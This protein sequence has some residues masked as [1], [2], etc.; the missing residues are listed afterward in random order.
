MQACRAGRPNAAGHGFQPGVGSVSGRSGRVCSGCPSGNLLREQ[1][2]GAAL[3]EPTYDRCRGA[4]G[5][6]FDFMENITEKKEGGSQQTVIIN[7]PVAKSNALG[8]AG[9][10]LALL[11][12][13]FCWVPVLDWILWILGLVFSFCGIF[14]APKGLAIAGLAISLISLILIIAVIGAIA[15]AFACM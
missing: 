14:K 4:G 6:N 3:S 13:V 12:L 9:F 7:Q 10:V 5:D 11:G 8:T 15:T 1:T 2:F